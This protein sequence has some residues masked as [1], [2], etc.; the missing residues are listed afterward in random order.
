MSELFNDTWMKHFE[1]SWNTEPELTEALKALGFNANIGYGFPNEDQPRGFIRI[2]Q[3]KV[4]SASRYTG[5]A[6]DWDLRAQDKHW[7]EWFNREVGRTGFCLA[8]ST[9]KLQFITGDYK[10][11]VRTPGMVRPFVKSFA[12]MGRAH[13]EYLSRHA[14]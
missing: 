9:G 12:A 13:A 6:L 3:G 4:V 7:Y 11:M 2:V 1:T 5:Q 8:Y 10:E 14:A